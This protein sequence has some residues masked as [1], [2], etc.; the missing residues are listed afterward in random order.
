MD[1]R[2]LLRAAGAA[3]LTAAA[4]GAAGAAGAAGRRPAAG[5]TPADWRALAASLDGSLVRPGGSGYDAARVLYDPRFDGIR[6][7]AVA[8]CATTADVVECVRFARRFG[9]ALVPRG[10]GHSYVGA[11]TSPHGLVLDTRPLAAVRYDAGTGQALVGGG[12]RLS[13]VYAGL[14]RHGVTVPAGS[15]G[16]VGI[17]G[18]ALGGG[19]GMASSLAGLTCDVV[20]GLDIVTADARW[21]TVDA[22]REPE[23]FWA[24]RGGGGGQFGVVTRWRMRTFAVREVGRFTL[25]WA[26]RDAAAVAAGWQRFLAQAGDRVWCHLQL[27]S[28]ARGRRGVR[29]A[30]FVLDGDPGPPA[31][32]L[33]AAAGREPA[34]VRVDRAPYL[35]VVRDRAGAGSRRTELLGSDVFPAPLPAAGLAALVAAVDRRAAARR[36]GVAKLK[37]LTGAVARVPVAATAFPWRGSFAMLQWLVTDERPDPAAVRDAYAWIAAGHR[38]VA[39]WSAGGYVNYLEPDPAALPRYHGAHLGRLRAVRRRYDPDRLFR[40]PYAL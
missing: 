38:A 32:A 19:V 28:D 11:S 39:R 3:G 40:S 4:G 22:R 33:V 30:G 20:T 31:H 5:P 2:A 21:R 17:G 35:S 27:S 29:A 9:L 13:D 25:H 15:C 6:P 8:R 10:G 16:G 23:L 1:R 34:Q 12:A 37:P 7:P 14:G 36:P 26:W 24:C 18:L